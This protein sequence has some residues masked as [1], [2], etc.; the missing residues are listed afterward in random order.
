MTDTFD[1]R[2]L[3]P[4]DP[5]WDLLQRAMGLICN[6]HTTAI[7]DLDD[8]VDTAPQWPQAARWWLD[9]YNEMLQARVKLCAVHAAAFHLE[10]LTRRH[11]AAVARSAAACKAAL[12][13]G[14]TPDQIDAA[15][16]AG[17]SSF[18]AKNPEEFSEAR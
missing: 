11:A 14:A 18:R 9:R 1:P 16:A 17:R 5:A 15:R 12:E 10:S 3:D 13:A 6:A 8:K 2:P 4:A 7:A